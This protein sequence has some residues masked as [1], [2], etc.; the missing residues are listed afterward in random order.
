[1]AIYMG[2]T[3]FNENGFFNSVEDAKKNINV[4]RNE[5]ITD[6]EKLNAEIKST[7]TPAMAIYKDSKGRINVGC[8]HYVRLFKS[9]KIL[10][11]V[12]EL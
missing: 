2:P 1:M 9:Y 7:Y 3:Y 4:Y 10:E 8:E 12:D 5:Q 11:I 6:N